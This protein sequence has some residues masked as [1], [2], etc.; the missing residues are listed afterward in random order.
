MPPL[1]RRAAANK[2]KGSKEPLRP[3]PK[4]KLTPGQVETAVKLAAAE[5]QKAAVEKAAALEAELRQ[6]R[7]AELHEALQV[8]RPV[9]R[10][11][12]SVKDGPLSPIVSDMAD[13]QD[14]RGG[15]G[16]EEEGGSKEGTPL[17]YQSNILMNTN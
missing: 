7:E 11:Q 6:T 9:A 2:A 1:T 12:V 13:E 16:G 14:P 4:I 3:V 8:T 5:K 15:S 17:V 10:R